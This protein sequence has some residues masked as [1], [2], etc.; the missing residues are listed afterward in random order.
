MWGRAS[1]AR[2]SCPL[3]T[4]SGG[5]AG[6]YHAHRLASL[7][8]GEEGMSEENVQRI[9]YALAG[10]DSSIRHAGMLVFCGF[11]FVGLAILWRKNS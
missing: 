2:D 10:L 11:L 9:G 6:R 1:V 3:D 4:T 8:R 5:Q 7:V